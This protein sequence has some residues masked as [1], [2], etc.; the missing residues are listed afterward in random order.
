MR[1]S[2]GQRVRETASGRIGTV[3]EIQWDNSCSDP[4]CC[5]GPY[6]STAWV[7]FPDSEW[8]GGDDFDDDCDR[9]FVGLEAA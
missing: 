6:P 7:V 3:R 1:L 8:E 4:D 9:E 2:E 5:G